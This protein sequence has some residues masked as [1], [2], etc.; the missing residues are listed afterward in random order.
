MIIFIDPGHGGNDP[1]AIGICG[2]RECDVVLKIGLILRNLLEKAGCRVI[3][4]REEDKT[5]SLSS[6]ADMANRANADFFISIHCNGFANASARGTES[7]SYPGNNIGEKVAEKI[8]EEIS[9]EFNI[10]NRGAKK[11]NFAV[12]RLSKMPA[13]L[14]ETAFI[15][16]QEEEKIMLEP[17]FSEKIADC[18]CNAISGHF[19]IP[20]VLPKADHWGKKHLDSLIKKGYIQNADLWQEFEKS[21]TIAM[22]LAITD[23]ITEVN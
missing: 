17:G 7:Y 20:K 6:R 14:V 12:L 22:I 16:N 9:G 4:S 13:V 8:T 23:K 5:V 10:P 11:E 2:T 3:M 18:I 1:G 21:P 15:T 19:G